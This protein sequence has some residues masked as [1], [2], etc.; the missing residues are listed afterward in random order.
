MIRRFRPPIDGFPGRLWRTVMFPVRVMAPVRMAA[1]RTARRTWWREGDAARDGSGPVVRI[2]GGPDMQPLEEGAGPL[3]HRTYS[4][5]IV[6]SSLDAE[7]L[8]E[9]FRADPNA[10]SPTQLATFA[11]DPAP[12]GG[13]RVGD[14]VEVK[15]PGPWNGPVRVAVTEPDRVRLETRD[16]HM[17]AGFIEFHG[18]PHRDRPDEAHA[19]THDVV[20]TIES[21]ARSGDVVFDTL[22]H[23]FGIARYVQTEMWV[24]VLEGLLETSGGRRHGRVQVR[25]VTY[26]GA[27]S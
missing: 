26:C 16:G 20:F 25:T 19:P 10:H 9:A 14:D 15:L 22:Y 8:V 24:Q 7:A 11:P 17:E 5:R 2:G 1:M 4:I 6:D 27:D 12:D 13:L 21:L 23:R 18:R 3:N